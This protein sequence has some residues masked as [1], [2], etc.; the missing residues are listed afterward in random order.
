MYVPLEKKGKTYIYDVTHKANSRTAVNARFF[1]SSLEEHY[2]SPEYSHLCHA[3]GG[4]AVGK[5]DLI[6][7]RSK[8]ALF[9]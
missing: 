3:V 5:L 6:M 8:C 4:V 9:F 2:D 1:V 7:L